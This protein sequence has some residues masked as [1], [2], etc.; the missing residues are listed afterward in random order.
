M[1]AGEEGGEL[2]AGLWGMVMLVVVM[3]RVEFEGG[4]HCEEVV[5]K[6]IMMQSCENSMIKKAYWCLKL[7]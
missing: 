6:N 2:E 7:F 3:R 4:N 1:Q 5:E